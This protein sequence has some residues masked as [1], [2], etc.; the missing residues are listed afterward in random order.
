MTMTMTMIMNKAVIKYSCYEW[1]VMMSNTTE[2]LSTVIN[3]S[4][5]GKNDIDKVGGKN[6]S[7]G[8][9]ILKT[10]TLMMCI[11]WQKQAKKSVV[12]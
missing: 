7:L 12:G 4:N 5:L 6:A 1:S 2:Q 10:W 3:L 8:E 11:N 9:M